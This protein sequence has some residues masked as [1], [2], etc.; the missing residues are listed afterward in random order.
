MSMRGSSYTRN[1]VGA[2]ALHYLSVGSGCGVDKRV[3]QFGVPNGAK[4]L[5]RRSLPEDPESFTIPGSD[6]DR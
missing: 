5:M 4:S 6:V 3:G 2:K 1:I